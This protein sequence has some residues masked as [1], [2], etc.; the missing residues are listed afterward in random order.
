MKLLSILSIPYLLPIDITIVLFSKLYER[1]PDIKQELKNSI[2]RLV[3]FMRS[4]L[5]KM[6]SN[7]YFYSAKFSCQMAVK[8]FDYS[9]EDSLRARKP[10]TASTLSRKKSMQQKVAKVEKS[11]SFSGRKNSEN[12]KNM[13]SSEIKSMESIPVNS[14]QTNLSLKPEPNERFRKTSYAGREFNKNARQFNRRRS[15]IEI[16]NKGAPLSQPERV[17]SQLNFDFKL[18]MKNSKSDVNSDSS[19]ENLSDKSVDGKVLDIDLSDIDQNNAIEI[20]NKA[21][22]WEKD[23]LEKCQRF[24]DSDENFDKIFEITKNSKE[25]M[26]YYW[27]DEQ[28]NIKFT[29]LFNITDADL[30]KFKDQSRGDEC[31]MD[32]MDTYNDSD[33]GLI[34]TPPMLQS[35]SV[36]SSLT[37]L[38][39]TV[40]QLPSSLNETDR[41]SLSKSPSKRQRKK[42]VIV[43]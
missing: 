29:E 34:E 16:G 31:N 32:H 18:D 24:K 13:F 27:H 12:Y 22:D 30:K 4:L 26:A 14:E 28:N 37:N 9:K 1:L 11:N 42:S 40:P 3:S 19:L 5:V 21:L 36:K 43:H 25:I 23:F 6:E 15:M 35:S 17:I 20:A 7:R 39:D 8:E 10:S 38:Y 2:F 33:D 41:G